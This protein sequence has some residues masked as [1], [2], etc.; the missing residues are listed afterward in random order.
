M[1][2]PPK[3]NLVLIGYRGAGKTSVGR[4]VARRLGYRFVDTDDLIVIEAGLPI[5]RIFERDGE[6]GF[7]DRET[8]AIRQVAASERAVISVGGGGIL[9][10]E[11]VSLLRGSGRLVWLTAPAEVLWSRIAV[12]TKSG[13]QRP[14]LTEHRGLDEVK[15]VLADREARYQAAADASVDATGDIQVVAEHVIRAYLSTG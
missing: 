3:A 1:D 12:D 6:A 9:R 8:E 14:P 5:A 11:N 10:D 7:R 2:N 13:E 15:N 4:E